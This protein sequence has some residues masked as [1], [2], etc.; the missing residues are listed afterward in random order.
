MRFD[1]ESFKKLRYSRYTQEELANIMGISV[2]TIKNIES[3][4]RKV[5]IE[6]QELTKA[7]QIL[8]AKISDYFIKD[9]LVVPFL[10]NK[11]GSTK[12][13]TCANI[14]YTLAR[15]Y[16]KRILLIDT[17]LQQNLTQHF[18]IDID[19]NKNFYVAFHNKESLSKHIRKTSYDNID[20]ITSHDALSMLETELTGMELREFRMRQ[21]LQ[22]VI[23]EGIYDFILIDCNPSLNLLN[24]SILYASNK[25]V[26][27]LEPSAFGLRGIQ[28]IVEF[29][30]KVR[31]NYD[32]LSIMGIL[33]NK[34]DNRKR[35][36]KDVLEVVEE[37]FGD[38]KLLFKTKI[39]VDTGIEQCQMMGEPLGVSFSKSR[40]NL[41]FIELTKEV[42]E[43]GV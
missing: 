34:F 40:A 15:E 29:V 13:T 18:N 1:R 33:V 12:T 38:R 36:P 21:I 30:E 7:C 24:R 9:S 43:R 22:P 25:I 20:I 26:I 5:D 27:P 42:I 16:D 6:N 19:D 37:V 8:G 23:D 4:R 2:E 11:G 32:G 35:V 3:G 28:Y 10:S 39:P 31:E 14:G 17:D 41:A